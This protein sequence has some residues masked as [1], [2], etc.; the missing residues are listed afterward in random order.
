[1]FDMMK[2]MGK[3]K[4]VQEKMKTAQESLGEITAEAEAGG[5]MVKVIVNGKKEV[6]KL[7]IDP[8]IISK[9]DAEFMQDLI[10]A[11]TNMAIQSVEVKSKEH[12]KKATEG[13]LPNIPGMDLNNFM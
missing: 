3:V 2:M 8:S 12:I 10:I 6:I 11:A 5:G 1:M 13:M 9:D 4:E 7:E